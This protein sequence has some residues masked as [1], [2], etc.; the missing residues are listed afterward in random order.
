MSE[1][2]YSVL[3]IFLASPSDLQEEREITQN[4][5][6]RINTSIGRNLD[7]HV[8][9][10]GWED[11]SP[12]RRRPQ[13]AIN[14]DLRECDL[15]LGL[16]WKRWGTQPGGDNE[17]ESGF[18]EEY[19]L[20][21]ELHDQGQMEEV[22]VYFKKIEGPLNSDSIQQ[23][24]KVVEFRE[25][26]DQEVL[27]GTFEGTEDWERILND[28]LAKYLTKHYSARQAGEIK[29][30]PRRLPVPEE[31]TGM[32][33]ADAS[34]AA[35]LDALNNEETDIPGAF[36]RAR[37][38]LYTQSLVNGSVYRTFVLNAEELAFLY[39]AR[40][41]IELTN[42]ERL[43]V[44]QTLLAD[45]EKLRPGWYWL[46]VDPEQLGQFLARTATQ[47]PLYAARSHARDLLRS[48]NEEKYRQAI[49]EVVDGDNPEEAR[50]ALGP[51][52]EN[53]Q[54]KDREFLQTV[55][56][57][58]QGDLAKTAWRGVLKLKAE[59]DANEAIQW[60]VDTSK[61]Q[62]GRYND[63]MDS[64]LEDASTEHLRTLLTVEA[65]KNRAKVV[66]ALRGEL[67]D[68]ELRELAQDDNL[69]VAAVALMGLIERG[70]DVSDQFI[71]DRLLP[72]HTQSLSSN[73]GTGGLLAVLSGPMGPSI[74]SRREV[75]RA[76]YSRW[77]EEEL[78]DGVWWSS[79][80]AL[81][82]QVLIEEHHDAH[83]DRLREDIREEFDGI[84]GRVQQAVLTGNNND[85]DDSFTKGSF[86]RAAFQAL[87]P[88]ATPDD[89]EIAREFLQDP[90]EST[91]TREIV[92][93]AFQIIAQHGGPAEIDVLW[94]YVR[95]E[96]T[97]LQKQAAALILDLDPDRFQEHALELLNPEDWTIQK[98][99]YRCALE[100]E[101]ELPT[102]EVRKYLYSSESKVRRGALPYLVRKIDQDAL[103]ELLNSY[104]KSDDI[105]FDFYY[106]DVIGWLDRLLYAPAPI[107]EHYREELMESLEESD[108]F[109][110]DSLLS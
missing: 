45:D 63:L 79:D 94:E 33:R 20:A 59:N 4:V 110:F 56:D 48:V 92:E 98:I 41:Q 38:H 103:E 51:L 75:L 1:R 102:V 95:S 49:H 8:E 21:C 10:R 54:E 76:L 62:R 74:Y 9:L 44:F 84:N 67:A 6:S 73:V 31:E 93:D 52:V 18:E 17:F 14:E 19:N 25:S 34:L 89:V 32:V 15:F 104:P 82:Y 108:A 3:R 70:E 43:S 68:G 90:H 105:D 36:E 47:N 109:I 37:A 61:E 100:N 40:Q 85:R 65:G 77:S 107:R 78:E 5:V 99:V 11:T 26:I 60:I 42:Q 12:S 35:V 24:Q 72:Q 30:A 39:N 16:V 27:F 96:D 80:G 28:Y 23:V 64:I 69:D 97:G 87:I 29:Q 88:H 50:L 81:R 13:E 91:F 58:Q 86:Y 53:P 71:N 101:Q 55:V 7:V 57:E 46:N 2:T 106:Y 22:A 66:D 83:G